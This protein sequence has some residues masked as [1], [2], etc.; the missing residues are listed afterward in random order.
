MS[1]LKNPSLTNT[2]S[3]TTATRLC[4]KAEETKNSAT[5]DIERTKYFTRENTNAT[6]GFLLLVSFHWFAYTCSL[7]DRKN[8]MHNSHVL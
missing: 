3:S 7:K 6:N 5:T 2:T 4:L 8:E 1:W